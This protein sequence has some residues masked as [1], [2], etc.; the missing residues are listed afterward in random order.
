MPATTRLIS[1]GDAERLASLQ[2]AGRAFFEPWDP[3]RDDAYFTI[4]GNRQK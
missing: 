2:V 4:K 3:I 1:T